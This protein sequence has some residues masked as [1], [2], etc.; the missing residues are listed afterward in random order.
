MFKGEV[1]V[2][3]MSCKLFRNWYEKNCEG[4]WAHQYGV[5]IDTI[6][7]PGWYVIID[8][9]NTSLLNFPFS[10]KLKNDLSMTG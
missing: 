3:P 8:L 10:K 5:K 9:A 2:C 1:R 7:Y 6:D 4:D